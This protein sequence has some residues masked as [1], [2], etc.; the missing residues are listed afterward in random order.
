MQ[1]AATRSTRLARMQYLLYHAPKGLT[2]RELAK[3]LDVSLRTIQRDLRT[4]ESE[5][6]VPLTQE[7]LRYGILETYILP[8][9]NFSLQEARALLIAARLFLRYSDESDPHGVAALERLAKVM[10]TP[11]AEHIQE[12]VQALRTKPQRQRFVQVLEN[13]T[14]AWA[15]GRLLRIRYYSRRRP[16]T[17]E[18]LVEPY[19]LE[20]TAPGYSTY[21]V[22]YS[23]THSQ[24]RTFKIERI[25]E[26]TVLE[27]SIPKR[28]DPSLVA[29][30]GRSWGIIWAEGEDAHEIELRF[31][32]RV[33]TR[34]RE[35]VWHPSQ[36]TEPLPDGGL[37]LRMAVPSL[38]EV[39]PWIRSWGPDVE[40][41]RPAGLRS[42]V[43][44]EAA[45][46]ARLYRGEFQPLPRKGDPADAGGAH[47][48]GR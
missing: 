37:I 18:A 11:V 29:A 12:T 48:R 35:A 46:L 34:V 39:L 20:A 42:T 24:V 33:A 21:L 28:R 9:V 14:N 7:G 31:S 23:R 44:R 30:I 5:M 25:Q 6:G 41:I 45:A 38:V 8:P 19:L 15:Q 40:V 36:R 22:G 2:A 13:I 1:R 10:P 17:H 26:A 43:A 4:L 3:R 27:E 16:A 47:R 32:P